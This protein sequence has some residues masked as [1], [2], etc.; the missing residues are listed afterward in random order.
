MATGLRTSKEFLPAE[1]EIV[2]AVYLLNA[3]P[4]AKRFLIER[5][6]PAAE[7]E[8]MPV[9]QVILVAGMQGY[10]GLPRQRFKWALLADA[11]ARRG[12]GAKVEMSGMAARRGDHPSRIALIPVV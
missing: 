2:A 9:P 1:E 8:A 7:V 11:E 10:N 6:K 4:K 3:Y 12:Y 5:G